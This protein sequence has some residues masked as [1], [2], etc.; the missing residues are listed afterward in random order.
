MPEIEKALR[1]EVIEANEDDVSGDVHSEERRK[2]DHGT[3]A[4]AYTRSAAGRSDASRVAAPP[5]LPESR[6][7]GVQTYFTRKQ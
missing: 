3:A 7:A 2:T 1:H 6:R 4:T 5:P